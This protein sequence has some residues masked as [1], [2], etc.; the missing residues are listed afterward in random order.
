MPKGRKRGR[1]GARRDRNTPLGYAARLSEYDNKGVCG[2]PEQPDDPLKLNKSLDRLTEMIRRSP[3]TVIHTG[4][5]IS[6]SAG[7]P[8]FRGE[9]GI[10][11]REMQAGETAPELETCWENAVSRTSA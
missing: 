9:R 10:W 11:T 8:D 1:N 5:G 6:T 3:H 7:I 2:I 4:A